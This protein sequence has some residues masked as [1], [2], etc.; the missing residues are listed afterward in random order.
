VRVLVTGY[1]GYIGCALVP[2]LQAH[3]HEVVGLDSHLFAGCD[4]STDPP[5]PRVIPKDVRDV[6]ESDLEGIEAI[7]HLAGI[8]NDP[9]GDLNPECTYDINH[10]ATIRLA[11]LAK[12]AGVPRF[13]QSSSCSLYGAHGDDLIDENARWN[14]VTPYGISKERVEHDLAKLADDDFSPTLLRNATAYGVSPRL[15]ADLVVNNLVGY[16]FTTGE[17]LLKS[18]GTPWRPLVHIED[19]SRA[20]VAVLNAPRETVH[21]QAFNV[22][23]T[24]QNYRIREVAEIV[25]SVVPG[26]RVEFSE[27][28]GPDKRNYRVNCDKIR[29]VLPE[30]ETQWTVPRGVEELYD[31]YKR[32]GLDLDEFLSSRYLRIKRVAELQGAG[33]LDESLRWT[34]AG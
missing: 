4:F 3:G 20:F 12:S 32:H 33:R 34:A 17:V 24:D 30:F 7:V 9:L 18:D 13:L 16:A 10:L 6:E 21:N 28:A 14:P 25:E 11:R 15:R 1:H 5:S 22:G 19:I 8:S 29:E 26:S 27:G 31:A 23:A 2:L